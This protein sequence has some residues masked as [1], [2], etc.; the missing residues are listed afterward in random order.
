MKLSNNNVLIGPTVEGEPIRIEGRVFDGDGAFVEDALVEIWQADAAGEYA[1]S[2]GG[3]SKFTGFGRAESDPTTGTYWFETIKPGR[4]PDPE[5]E[6]QA[7]HLSVIVQA[8]GMLRPV[9]TRLYF[10][11]EMEANDADLILRMVPPERRPTLLA[12][13]ARVEDRKVYRFDVHLQGVE[14]TV[15]FD[16]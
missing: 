4:V 12:S 6:L 8:R 16:F 1:T 15:F 14:E 5:G 2:G 9:F 13:L 7:P 3:I 10:S 11:D